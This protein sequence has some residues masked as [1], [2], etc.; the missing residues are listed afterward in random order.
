MD[1]E[2][3]K[4]WLV[5]TDWFMKDGCNITEKLYGKEAEDAVNLRDPQC[6]ELNL[7]TDELERIAWKHKLHKQ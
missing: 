2:E 3:L 6:L 4:D 5:F 1:K 7:Y